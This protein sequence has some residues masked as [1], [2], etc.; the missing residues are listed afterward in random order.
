MKILALLVLCLGIFAVLLP[1]ALYLSDEIL[2]NP[3]SPYMQRLT[4]SDWLHEGQRGSQLEADNALFLN[5]NI[6]NDKIIT[7]LIEGRLSLC[8]AA[9][10]MRAVHE[11]KPARL[12]VWDDRP[13]E[14]SVEEYFVRRTIRWVEAALVDDPRRDAVL[15]RLQA[16]LDDF[17]YTQAV[18]H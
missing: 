16:E 9:D 2:P 4:L 6:E 11:N 3:E 15:M 7:Q 18:Q 8:A 12:C 5:L 17:L 14:Q 13:P 10:A 1:A